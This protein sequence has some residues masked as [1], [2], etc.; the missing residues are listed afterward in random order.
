MRLPTA[1]KPCYSNTIASYL[2]RLEKGVMLDEIDTKIIMLLSKGIKNKNLSKYIPL[3]DSAI[4][5]RKYKVKKMLDVNGD[6]EALINE[7]RRQ[8]YI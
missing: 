1:L 3:S 4:E 5:K 7:A 2:K 8:G 6:D